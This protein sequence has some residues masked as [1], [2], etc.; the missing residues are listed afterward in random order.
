MSS[1]LFLGLLI[2]MQHALEADHVAAVASIAATQKT[3]RSIIA[4]GAVWGIGHT[5]T[6]MLLAGGAFY[7][8][9]AVEARIAE[10]LETGVGVMLVALGAHVLYRLWR[11]RVHFHLH[12]HAGRTPHFH[13]HA[14]EPD[15]PHDS[16]AH[17]HNHPAGVPWR[18]L[19]VGMMHGMA[20]SA[21]LLVLTASS[22]VE[23]GL[24]VFYIA[25]FGIGSVVGMALLSAVMAVPLTYTARALTWG[26]RVL[27]GG[28]GM[29]TVALGLVIIVNG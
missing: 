23:S 10:W 17:D 15:A 26:H 22:V 9:K 3:R 19:F 13:A 8:G 24:A 5:V 12:R 1:V 20:G 28:I 25:L 6:L 27:Q 11:E 14:H 21:A 7:M 2:G 29:G 18:A 16:R 4:H